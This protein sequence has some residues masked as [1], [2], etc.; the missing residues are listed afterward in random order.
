M[1]T[2][3]SIN[4]NNNNNNNLHKSVKYD[5]YHYSSV[6]CPW[7][8]TDHLLAGYIIYDDGCHLKKFAQ[9]PARR[10]VTRTAKRLSWTIDSGGK[11]H[12]K[13]HVDQWCKENCDANN[14]EELKGVMR[15]KRRGVQ[16]Y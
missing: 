8:S 9:N 16:C 14:V 15:G 7:P 12:M 1:C 5:L 2:E 4:N 6:P 3:N 13:G 11:I 10:D